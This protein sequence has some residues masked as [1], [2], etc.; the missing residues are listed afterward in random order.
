MNIPMFIIFTKPTV[1]KYELTTY[2]CESLEDCQNKLI[3]NIK[4]KILKKV[5]YPPDLETFA[6]TA[7]YNEY[8][9]ENYIYDYQIFLDNKW[10][11]PW[12]LEELYES[13]IEII[14]Q[15]DL[16]NS[17]YNDKNYYDYCSD[18]EDEEKEKEK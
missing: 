6:L 5:E 16:Q 3:V 2:V 12:S 4:N 11:K 10:Q 13:V 14:H 17:I 9:M 7:W 15:V 8:N 1:P 18:D